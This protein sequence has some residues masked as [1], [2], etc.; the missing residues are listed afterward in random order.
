MAGPT[1]R[2]TFDSLNAFALSVKYN[3]EIVFAKTFRVSKLY[4]LMLFRPLSFQI[5]ENCPIPANTKKMERV[6][7]FK[8]QSTIK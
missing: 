6:L 3:K 8:R 7:G 2:V 4:L 1:I 5:E